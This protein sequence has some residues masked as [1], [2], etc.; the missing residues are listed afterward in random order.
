MLLSGKRFRSKMESLS[1]LN[2]LG[3]AGL[4][5]S[6]T[7]LLKKRLDRLISSQCE[8][9]KM[10]NLGILCRVGNC[11]L[12]RNIQRHIAECSHPVSG[13][14][15]KFCGVA[16]PLFFRFWFFYLYVL[17]KCKGGSRNG[18]LKVITGRIMGSKGSQSIT[19]MFY[20]LK[21]TS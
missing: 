6:H 4:S 10:L 15:A 18:Q 13:Y 5:L 7:H 16:P 3:Y 2:H 11:F 1:K 19:R 14:D 20:L 21:C 8:V 9:E 17:F 12:S